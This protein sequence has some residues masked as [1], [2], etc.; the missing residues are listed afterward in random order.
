MPCYCVFYS[1]TYHAMSR[2]LRASSLHLASVIYSACL[3]SCATA[4]SSSYLYD[5]KVSRPGLTSSLHCAN[6][7]Q[8][9][10][11]PG[12]D[13]VV[14][15]V[16]WMLPDLTV[17][18][19]DQGRFQ[20]LDG[21]WT[22][23]ITNVSVDDLGVYR[24]LLSRVDNNSVQT[25]FVLR[26]GL[27]AAGPYFSDLWPKYRTQTV[28]GLL[29][30]CIFLLVTVMMYVAYRLRS[31]ARAADQ[32]STELAAGSTDGRG[33]VRVVSGVVNKATRAQMNCPSTHPD[34][35]GDYW[36]ITQL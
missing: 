23:H 9:P 21:N 32:S 12:D 31:E 5:E 7:T 22:L 15:A 36:H 14:V 1:D 26:L 30:S 19:G 16:S 25:W 33:S 29:A 20:L 27:N 6:S 8:Y 35:G 34:S 11:V 18:H 3:C 2:T 13:V 24:C 17:L 10:A 28:R 4:S